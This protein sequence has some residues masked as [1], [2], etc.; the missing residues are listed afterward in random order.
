MKLKVFIFSNHHH[1]RH[2]IA[3]IDLGHLFT[4]S[5]LTHPEVCSAVFPGS[6]CIVD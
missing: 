1:H 4:R 6:F 3:I 2:P 5:F